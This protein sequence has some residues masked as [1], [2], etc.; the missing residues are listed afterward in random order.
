MEANEYAARQI[1]TVSIQREPIA[2]IGTELRVLVAFNAG[3]VT[4]AMAVTQE[5]AGS[6]YALG[7]LDPHYFSQDRIPARHP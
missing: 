2:A 4:P 7:F 5:G 1:V 3:S 6:D